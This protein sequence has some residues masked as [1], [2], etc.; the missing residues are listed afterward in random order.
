MKV[1]AFFAAILLLVNC[2]RAD[3]V[4]FNSGG[5]ELYGLGALSGQNGWT[6]DVAASY[7]VQDGIGAGGS[8]GVTVTG[9]AG[10]DWAYPSLNYTPGVGIGEII[11]I[12][13]DISRTV[14]G[15][16]SF[17]YAIDVYSSTTQ[18]ILRFGL[19]NSGGSI[20]PFVTSTTGNTSAIV[21]S[22]VAANTFVS[23]RTDL[24]FDTKTAEVFING[25]SVSG[26]SSFA[27]INAATTIGDA[28]FQVSTNAAA[29]DSGVLDNYKVS[30]IVAVPEPTSLL[31]SIIPL[32]GAIYCRSRRSKKIEA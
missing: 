22:S 28:D 11:R 2:G 12:E 17:G 25:T 27:F 14:G 5:F 23:F 9:G 29:L 10:T 4:L 7:Q 30:S 15:T 20:F 21:G 24:N 18:R 31:L 16:P 1:V 19:I 32:V 26:S 6:N 8:R 13:A 3:M